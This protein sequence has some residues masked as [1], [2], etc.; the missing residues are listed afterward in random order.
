M[1][2][3]R[4][5]RPPASARA[6]PALA[7]LPSLALLALAAAGAA[8]L[9]G[10]AAARAQ[11][12]LGD[13]VRERE[14][15][16]A[17]RDHAAQERCVCLDGDIRHVIRPLERFQHLTRRG[18][19]GVLLGE[20]ADAGGRTGVRLEEVVEG[21]PAD[22]AGLEAG[23]ILVALDGE[24][25]GDDPARAVLEHMADVEPGDTLA[26]R[27]SR[28]G[29]ERT[30]RVVADEN[31]GAFSFFSGDGPARIMVAPRPPRAPG[32]PHVFRMPAPPDAPDAPGAPGAMI[33]RSED[34]VP[35][36]IRMG[37]AGR[38]GL[39]LVEV[40]EG[41]GRYFG[42]DAGVLVA[43]VTEDTGLGLQPGDV[44]VAIG[45]REV[46]SPRHARSILAS[47]LPDE[48]V[49]IRVVRDRRTLTVRG[50]RG[51]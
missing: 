22:R 7:S 23:D 41:L 17:E 37:I 34:D 38:D 27:Y 39:E 51:G 47:Y 14:R 29:Q 25:L 21:G 46:R 44:I 26:L 43:D 2:P 3:I 48:E 24:P 6:R 19:I 49:A 31:D 33:W 13:P 36:L 50:T 35:G 18:R 20:P 9:L 1:H 28:D 16:E 42:V 40:N 11:D 30:A 15:V 4:R 45:D 10:P 32:A 8:A 12:P 5:P